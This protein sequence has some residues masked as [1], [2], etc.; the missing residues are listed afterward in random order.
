MGSKQNKK[1]KKKK[2]NIF[3]SESEDL[4]SEMD[5]S[6]S[7]SAE[8]KKDS[9]PDIVPLDKVKTKEID[10]KGKSDT[11]QVKTPEIKKEHKKEK[12]KDKKE[13]ETKLK[14]IV[15]KEKDEEEEIPKPTK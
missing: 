10:S 9:K 1:Q 4:V 11:K 7:S 6:A 13:D 2:S 15:K 8:D 5:V 14:E 12:S 3:D